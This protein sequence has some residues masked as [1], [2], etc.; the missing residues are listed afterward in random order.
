MIMTRQLFSWILRLVAAVILLQTLYFKF[1]AAPESVAIF[2]E[3]GLEPHGRIG[4]GFAEL[5]ASILL[6]LPATVTLGA[7]LG[8]GLMAGAIMSHVMELGFAGEMFSLAMLAVVVLACCLALLVLHHRELPFL[9]QYF[10]KDSN[11]PGN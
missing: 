3:L 1:T 2:T 8:T 9:K 4:I 10:E 7:L 11:T 6:L 5:A